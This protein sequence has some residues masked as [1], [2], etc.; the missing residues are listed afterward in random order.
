MSRLTDFLTGGNGKVAAGRLADLHSMF[1]GD[2]ERIYAQV[3]LELSNTRVNNKSYLLKFATN[4]IRNYSELGA[5]QLNAVA[6][7]LGTPIDD[8]ISQF[9]NTIAKHLRARWVPEQLIS[10]DNTSLTANHSASIAEFAIELY[11][12]L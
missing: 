11:N 7:P 5:I 12:Y 2:Y 1:N 8:T 10:G 9:Y 3:F 6:A 4:S